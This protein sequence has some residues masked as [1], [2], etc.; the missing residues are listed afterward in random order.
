M[1]QSSDFPP[2]IWSTPSIGKTLRLSLDN[3]MIKSSMQKKVVLVTQKNY[4]RMSYLK[5]KKS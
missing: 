2:S 5:E 3:Q 1:G 4:F